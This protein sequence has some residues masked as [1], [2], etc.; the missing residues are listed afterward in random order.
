VERR[1]SGEAKQPQEEEACNVNLLTF[2][3][4]MISELP[5]G[6]ITYYRRKY[7]TYLIT[8]ACKPFPLTSTLISL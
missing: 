3:E 1:P 7:E 6:T 4:L 5:L 2:R 8:T